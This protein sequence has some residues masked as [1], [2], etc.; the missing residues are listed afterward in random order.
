MSAHTQECRKPRVEWGE[1]CGVATQECSRPY[2]VQ[3]EFGGGERSLT[4]GLIVLEA[5]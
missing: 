3:R 1:L 5:E 4:P 2:C